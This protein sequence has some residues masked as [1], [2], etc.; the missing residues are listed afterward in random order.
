MNRER[1]VY[2]GEEWKNILSLV[3]TDLDIAQ[4]RLGTSIGNL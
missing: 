4:M 2:A 3:P 1:Q